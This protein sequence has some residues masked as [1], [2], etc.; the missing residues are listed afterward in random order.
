MM[1]CFNNKT[2]I[3]RSYGEKSLESCL[4][5]V[6]IYLSM[7]SLMLLKCV[8]ASQVLL[9]TYSTKLVWRQRI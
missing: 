1:L 5:P 7:P 3:I 9:C 6:G 8:Q 4:C 2:H